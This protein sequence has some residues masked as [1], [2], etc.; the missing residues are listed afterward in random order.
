MKQKDTRIR[1]FITP[2]FRGFLSFLVTILSFMLSTFCAGGGIFAFS[3]GVFMLIP[4]PVSVV[5]SFSPFV[6]LFGGFAMIS[7]AISTICIFVKGV[8]SVLYQLEQIKKRYALLAS[9]D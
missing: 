6:I 2:C 1:E 3:A 9:H 7:L 5:S 8:F 4:M